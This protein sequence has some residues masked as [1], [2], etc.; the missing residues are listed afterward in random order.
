MLKVSGEEP[1]AAGVWGLH[2]AQG[3]PSA[4]PLRSEFGP[5]SFVFH[6]T[7]VVFEGLEFGAQIR[8]HISGRVCPQVLAKELK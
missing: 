6:G 1:R 2:R 7:L 3:S 5:V 4:S 8:V